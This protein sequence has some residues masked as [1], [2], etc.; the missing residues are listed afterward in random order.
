MA[1]LLILVIMIQRSKA[2]GGLG[3]LATTSPGMEEAFGSSAGNVL[4]KV[5]AW[6]AGIFLVNTLLIGL[7]QDQ[8]QR[9]AQRDPLAR[10]GVVVPG[11]V[12][13]P[14]APKSEL[15]APAPVPSATPRAQPNAPKT[16]TIPAAGTDPG[17]KPSAAKP[18]EDAA[19]PA[20]VPEPKPAEGGEPTPAKP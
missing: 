5:T 17:A 14:A 9:D 1:V 15:E 3:G 13:K 8:V 18:S 11:R 7:I 4:N 2:G 6:M 16:K 10:A 12:A 19:T 20:A